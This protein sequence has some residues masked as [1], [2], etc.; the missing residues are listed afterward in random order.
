MPT[1]P[2]VGFPDG[3]PVR[4]CFTHDPLAT[5]VSVI[6]KYVDTVYSDDPILASLLKG[7]SRARDWGKLLRL[8]GGMESQL[9]SS[10]YQHFRAHQFVAFV[11]K[12]P[13]PNGTLSEY[14]SDRREAAAMAKFFVSEELCQASNLTHHSRT[15]DPYASFMEEMRRYILFVLGDKPDLMSI[16]DKCDFGP[17]ASVG[18][19]GDATNLGRKLLSEEWSCSPMALPYA[20]GALWSND[21][22]RHLILSDYKPGSIVSLDPVLFREK[23]K[24]RVKHVNYNTIC[25]VPKTVQ[26]DRTIAIEPVLNGF[27]QKGVDVHMREKL[28][29]VGIDLSDQERNRRL[30]YLGSLGVPNPYVTIDLSSASDSISIELVRKLLPSAWFELL[31]DLRSTH[32]MSDDGTS[33]RYHKFTSMGNGFCFPLETLLFAAAV[34]AAQEFCGSTYPFSV[35]GDDIICH[36]N[37]ALLVIELLQHMGFKT[38]SDKTFITGPFRESCGADWYEG[39]DVRPVYLRRNLLVANEVFSFHNEL[40]RKDKHLFD[41]VLVYLRSLIPEP[42]RFLRPCYPDQASNGAFDADFEDLSH[43]THVVWDHRSWSYRWKELL[44]RPVRDRLT[45]W[46]RSTAHACEYLAVLRGS[47]ATAP[48]AYRRKTTTSVRQVAY[49]GG[50][51]SF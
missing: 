40:R 47:A 36:Q 38:N 16:Y 41:A 11:K 26:I 32:Y 44:A 22:I 20:L 2:V 14:D 34:H 35:Y 27:L 3:F 39:Q 1:K 28:L 25:C 46:S 12:Y 17:G 50:L 51:T 48:L 19:A 7:A 42:Y 4:E 29:R 49:N 37:E 24:A 13:F 6:H 23:V 5:L 18:V 33:R 30:A 15:W 31:N 9:Y 45:S 8:T 21:Q 10:P 43:C